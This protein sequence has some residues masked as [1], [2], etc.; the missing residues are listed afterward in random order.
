MDDCWN[1]IDWLLGV[2]TTISLNSTVDNSE[3]NPWT[4]KSKSKTQMQ[5]W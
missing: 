4:S 3:E 2:E 5:F 1:L